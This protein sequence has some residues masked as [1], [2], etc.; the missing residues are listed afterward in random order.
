ML[1]TNPSEP[2]CW[3]RGGRVEKKE[4]IDQIMT[5]ILICLP[6]AHNQGVSSVQPF[7]ST[8][9]AKRLVDRY[10]V[11][12]YGHSSEHQRRHCRQ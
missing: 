8:N 6:L 10:K 5:N 3:E 1:K 11:R 12:S 4:S 2:Y 7:S 9:A